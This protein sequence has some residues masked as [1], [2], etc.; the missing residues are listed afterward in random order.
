[1]YLLCT[2][3]FV[4]RQEPDLVTLQQTET[5]GLLTPG[6]RDQPGQRTKA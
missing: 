3:L 6:A 1:M 5:G 2:F 4:Q